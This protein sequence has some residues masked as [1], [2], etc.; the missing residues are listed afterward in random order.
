MPFELIGGSRAIETL[1][2]AIAAAS[3][4]DAK[5]L[6]TGESGSGK[7]VAARLLHASSRRSARPFLPINCAA[8]PD[9]LLESELFGHLRGTFTGATR[10]RR[11]LLESAQGGTVLLDEVGEMTPR[12]QGLL[13]RFMETGEIQRLGDDRPHACVDVRVVV[14]THRNLRY[15]VG[16]GRFRLDLFYRINV[17]HLHVPALRERLEDVP[18]LFEHF[19]TCF[20]RKYRMSRPLLGRAAVAALTTYH[21]PGN[22]RELQNVAERVAVSGCRHLVDP[23]WLARTGIA[24]APSRRSDAG[25][26]AAG[27]A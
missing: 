3:R 27:A 22:V 2:Q 7:E 14:A 13:L 6:I 16:E 25:E 1:R 5:V 26:A 21:W 9:S 11:G 20:C 24:Q 19:L 17:V 4:C 10:D 18:V 23:D 15:E 12:M 8:I